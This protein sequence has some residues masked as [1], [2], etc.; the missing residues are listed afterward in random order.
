M[1]VEKRLAGGGPLKDLGIY[2]DTRNV[3]YIRYGT[4]CRYCTGR[5]KTDFERF[6]EV[7]QSLTW[8]F[9]FPGGLIGEGKSVMRMI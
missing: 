7:E 8:Q 4:Y 2:C 3:L 5:Q 1:A 9:D 6:K